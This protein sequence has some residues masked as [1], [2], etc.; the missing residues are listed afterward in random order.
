[1]IKLDNS[2]TFDDNQSNM[3]KKVL[4]VDDD[5]YIRELYEEVMKTEGYDV[6]SASD[7]LIAYDLLKK[8]GFDLILLD[9]MLPKMDGFRIL[10]KL[11]EEPPTKPNGVV[12]LLTNLDHGPLIKDAFEKGVT[13]FMVKADI[14]PSDLINS[15][16]KYLD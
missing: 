8:G 14:T 12:I 10:D 11:K 9:V 13:E 4:V 5:Q 3:A 15:A 1:M 16:H 2:R 6:E 7:G